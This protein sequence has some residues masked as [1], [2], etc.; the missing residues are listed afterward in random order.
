MPICVESDMSQQQTLELP[1]GQGPTMGRC[2]KAQGGRAGGR[3]EQQS[4]PEQPGKQG[5]N[6]T[7][8][9]ADQ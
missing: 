2:V 3:W 1:R 5:D 9:P 7:V 6:D 8:H 4:K